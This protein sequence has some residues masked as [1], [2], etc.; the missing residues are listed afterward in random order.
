[1][2]YLE[3]QEE[4]VETMI[5]YYIITVCVNIHQDRGQL[6]EFTN[7][8]T[9][10]I[11]YI[12]VVNMQILEMIAISLNGHPPKDLVIATPTKNHKRLFKEECM[13]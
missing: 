10:Q 2:L 1:M 4:I 8:R 6:L 12:I 5:I 11:G 7:Q 9:T 3:I 13:S